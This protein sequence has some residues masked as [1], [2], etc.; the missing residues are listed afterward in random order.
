MPEQQR[1]WRPSLLRQLRLE[2]TAATAEA[3]FLDR[4]LGKHTPALEDI[5]QTRIHKSSFLPPASRFN[6]ICSCLPA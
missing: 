5:R 6:Y 1:G 4:L 3:R 2:Q